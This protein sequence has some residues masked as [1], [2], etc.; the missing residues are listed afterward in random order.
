MQQSVMFG[1]PQRIISDR[2]TAFTSKN[3]DDYCKDQEIEHVTIV[4]GVP[5]INRQIECINRIVTPIL[6]N[7]RRTRSKGISM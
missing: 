5:R 3:F 7:Q 4:T 6:T 1:N 2:G